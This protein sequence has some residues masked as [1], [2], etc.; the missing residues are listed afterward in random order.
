MEAPVTV[1]NSSMGALP[2]TSVHPSVDEPV[3]SQSSSENE[4]PTLK[5]SEINKGKE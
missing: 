3:V 4:Q 2:E 1:E 5:L